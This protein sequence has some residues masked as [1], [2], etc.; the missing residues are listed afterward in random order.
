MFFRRRKEEKPTDS[1]ME[2]DG[3]LYIEIGQEYDADEYETD[4]DYEE[5]E[6]E[7]EEKAR[8]K[9]EE[10]SYD[11]SSSDSDSDD[12]ASGEE[13]SSSGDSSTSGDSTGSGDCVSSE[14]GES[15]PE[16]DETKDSA[17]PNT[18]FVEE[19]IVSEA[20]IECNHD[21]IDNEKPYE[22]PSIN[23]NEEP[24]DRVPPI[25]NHED[26]QE[27]E[28][29]PQDSMN[30]PENS[31]QANDEDLYSNETNKS[32]TENTSI[33]EKRSLLAL[34]AEHDRVD[35]IKTILQPPPQSDAASDPSLVKFL[36]NNQFKSSSS[37][38]GLDAKE[39]GPF[40][41][42]LHLAIASAS[43]NAATCLLRMGANPA[44][45]PTL[46]E[47]WTPH[48]EDELKQMEKKENGYWNKFDGLSAWELA[49]GVV[50]D[51]SN[52]AHSSNAIRGTN[53]EGGD[54]NMSNQST[55]RKWFGSWSSSSSTGDANNGAHEIAFDISPSK[56]EGIK[57]AFT[58]EALRAIGADEVNRFCELLDSGL[59]H[60]LSD[61]EDRLEIGGKD[62]LG[63]CME[64]QANQ[65]IT[66][67]K[68]RQTTE[69]KEVVTSHES[70]ENES[71]DEGGNTDKTIG[72]SIESLSQM[73]PHDEVELTSSPTATRIIY[74]RGKLEESESLA[75]ALSSMLD[76]L[77]EEAAVSQAL[78]FQ[79][80]N[81]SNEGLLSQVR[82][83]KQ[84][85][86]EKED[87]ISA[88]QSRF[89]ETA[90]ELEMV[91]IWLQKRGGNTEDVLMFDESKEFATKGSD[92]KL[93]YGEVDVTEM[94]AHLA[95][96]E[97]KV[98]K[99]RASISTLA[100]ENTKN[101]EKIEKL[102]LQGAVK[103]A[104]KLREEVV[105]A[106]D[107]LQDLKGRE[108]TCRAKVSLVRKYL[109]EDINLNAGIRTPSPFNPEGENQSGEANKTSL[110]RDDISQDDS[111]LGANNDERELENNLADENERPKGDD[112]AQLVNNIGI[113]IEED[114]EERIQAV[115]QNHDRGS[116]LAEVES[117]NHVPDVND[118]QE[119]EYSYELVGE[120]KHSDKIRAGVSTAIVTQSQS[121][122]RGF[123]IWSF[124]LRVIGLGR[125]SVKKTVASSG[126]DVLS[127]VP[128]VMIV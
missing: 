14:S 6:E 109:E 125:E 68:K 53:V 54:A 46:P 108:A 84:A 13:E 59:D 38:V 43:T 87:E 27:R 57:H 32:D 105:K 93:S 89:A 4:S 23:S 103:L 80:G 95:V 75:T 126:I 76:N 83:L 62:L 37:V 96:S 65:C 111:A 5:G 35:I 2:K 98:R 64:M 29:T 99:L 104:R 127:G 12:D 72:K 30:A 49:F 91:L 101:L 52:E 115:G 77:A 8:S 121:N 19:E 110:L 40:L 92:I 120:S 69:E 31:N 71:R 112:D 73:E 7:E 51:G 48:W 97:N 79:N 124:I 61:H 100:E 70:I 1:I 9:K 82:L 107:H 94:R 58:A 41:P 117:S 122:G 67:L 128:R 21:E 36:L 74:L 116:S 63:W 90:A 17:G 81:S 86:A 44:I 16:E 47:G 106:G 102:G 15:L 39:D 3:S 66:A 34:A 18:P 50:T 25:N 45:R 119:S 88:W 20:V 55:S 22:E 56:L 33:M 42:P 114:E 11:G 113:R 118:P 85:R 123:D 78:V 26:H 10:T 24:T 28:S 60:P